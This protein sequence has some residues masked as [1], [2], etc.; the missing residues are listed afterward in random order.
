MRKYMIPL[1]L[2]P[3]SKQAHSKRLIQSASKVRDRAVGHDHQTQMG[4][5][6]SRIG[7]IFQ[8]RTRS[9]IGSRV[10]AG[11]RYIAIPTMEPLFAYR[12]HAA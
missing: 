2:R 4:N 11:D 12:R 8:I 6:S 7:K 9:M 3:R 10:V 1:A 5:C